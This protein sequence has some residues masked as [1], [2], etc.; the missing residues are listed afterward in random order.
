[1]TGIQWRVI[2]VLDP[3]YPSELYKIVIDRVDGGALPGPMTRFI[4]AEK[5]D[6]AGGRDAVIGM[7]ATYEEGIVRLEYPRQAVPT[8]GTMFGT[9]EEVA[10]HVCMLAPGHQLDHVCKCG[11]REINGERG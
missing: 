9:L 6:E 11:A 5:L 8:C 3:E 2:E 10:P 4:E 7:P 1:M